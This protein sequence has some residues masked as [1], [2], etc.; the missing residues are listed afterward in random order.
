[1]N[2]TTSVKPE[3]WNLLISIAEDRNVSYGE[4]L[5]K[6]FAVN[7]TIGNNPDDKTVRIYDANG[8]EI[9]LSKGE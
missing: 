9:W 1:M 7:D 8:G 3:V 2:I 5:D 6:G 4:V